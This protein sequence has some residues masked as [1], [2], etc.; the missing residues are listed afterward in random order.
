[1][2]APY[3]L[4]PVPTI[5]QDDW[6]DKR[7]TLC[8][9]MSLIHNVFIRSVNT[10]WNNA[11]LVT[12]QDEVSFAGYA[13]TMAAAIHTHHHSEETIVFPFLATKLPMEE[14]IEQHEQ[15]QAGLKEFTAYFQEVF[16]GEARY[17]ATKTREL[18]ASFGGALVQHL[19]DEIPTISPEALSVL[20][21][22]G[23]D[24]MMLELEEHIKSA[25][26]LFTVFP[27]TLSNHDYAA[28]PNWPP[29]PGPLSWFV[30]HIAVWRHS[31]YWK[32]SS[33]D[34]AGRPKAY[35]PGR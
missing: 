6:I 35:S 23:F 24:K 25:P 15:F 5:S 34:M 2:Q 4:I 22:E 31:S 18:V 21:T 12:P 20:D 13:L 3:P 27:F 8:W 7:K 17:D 1:M 30:R 16:N 9:D 10:V 29:I 11:P 28:T 26:G 14:N 19:H 32:F 33:F